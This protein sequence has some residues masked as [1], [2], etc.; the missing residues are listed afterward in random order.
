MSERTSGVPLV[1]FVLLV[2]WLCPLEEKKE[3]CS[4]ERGNTNLF[5]EEEEKLNLIIQGIGFAASSV[6]GFGM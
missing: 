2:L 6:Y 3:H 1:I 5:E 4:A